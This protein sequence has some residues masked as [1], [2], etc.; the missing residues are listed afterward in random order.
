[1]VL[2]FMEDNGNKFANQVC[3]HLGVKASN[4]ARWHPKL[5]SEAHTTVSPLPVI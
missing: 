2:K 3:Q 1:M 4:Y 5:V